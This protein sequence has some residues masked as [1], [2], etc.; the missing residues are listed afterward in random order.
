[1]GLQMLI[2]EVGLVATFVC[3]EKASLSLV[4]LEVIRQ[5][6]WSVKGFVAT[7]V[8]AFEVLQLRW[9]LLPSRSWSWRERCKGGI[10]CP[11]IVG[12][13]SVVRIV[14]MVF[15]IERGL[16]SIVR[17]LTDLHA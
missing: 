9:K 12:V 13:I 4:R 8:S 5:S 10:S 1:M 2:L 17:I 7:L 11:L 16:C 3:T 6:N 14:F 15:V